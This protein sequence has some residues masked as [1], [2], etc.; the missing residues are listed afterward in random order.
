MSK[1][2][3]KSHQSNTALKN[4]KA[5]IKNRGGVLD[6]QEDMGWGTKIKY[7]YPKKGK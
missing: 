2:Y 1:T 7:H 6:K 3:V 5:K 4:H